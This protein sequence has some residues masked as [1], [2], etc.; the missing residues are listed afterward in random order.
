[1]AEEEG[2]GPPVGCP[3]SDFESGALNHSATLPLK[4][5]DR[6]EL[7]SLTSSLRTR[8]S[9]KLS[10]RPKKPGAQDRDRTCMPFYGLM[11]L[12]HACLPISPPG[13][14][15]IGDI[16]ENG[17]GSSYA[18]SRIMPYKFL[19]LSENGPLFSA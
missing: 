6:R 2:F 17:G 7:E 14:L 9:T 3:T 13:H 19:S 4:M 1:M 11:L 12:K 18:E 10:Y 15:K 5:V 8:R 16:P